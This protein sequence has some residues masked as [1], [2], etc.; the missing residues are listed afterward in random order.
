VDFLPRDHP[1]GLNMASAM[2]TR[3]PVESL[4]DAL[5]QGWFL[6]D[7]DRAESFLAELERELPPG[8]MLHG[9]RVSVVAHR[10]ATDDILCRHLDARSRFTVIHL[11]WS[12]KQERDEHHPR[13][14]SD[15]DFDSFLAYEARQLAFR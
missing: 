4:P 14:E 13:V 2:L 9:V 12:R 3:V 11:T 15:G 5:P 6:S 10:E 8:H 1:P 7:Q